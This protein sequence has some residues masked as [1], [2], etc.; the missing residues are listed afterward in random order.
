M[1]NWFSKLLADTNEEGRNIFAIALIM[2]GAGI[3][4]LP[5]YVY[6]AIQQGS[7]QL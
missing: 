5:L 2:F 7:W 6:L 4:S 3:V 1:K